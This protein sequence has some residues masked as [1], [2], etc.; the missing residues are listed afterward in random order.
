MEWIGVKDKLPDKDGW[1]LVYAPRYCGRNCIIKGYAYSNFKCNY[2]EHWGIERG[3][4]NGW[5]GIVTHW[6]PLPKPPNE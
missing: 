3:V 4:S 5:A 1:Y 6:S 2:K